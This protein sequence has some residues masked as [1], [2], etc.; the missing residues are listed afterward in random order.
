MG[1]LLPPSDDDYVE[2]YWYRYWDADAQR[3]TVSKWMATR[4]AI[5]EG[6]E[7]IHE[8]ARRVHRSQLDGFG[9]LIVTEGRMH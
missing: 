5:G 7:P 4:E 9:R 1:Q 6:G 8:T 2:V 3:M